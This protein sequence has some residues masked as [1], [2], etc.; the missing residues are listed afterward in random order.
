MGAIGF[1]DIKKSRLYA[2]DFNHKFRIKNKVPR[3]S[4]LTTKK[5]N[6]DNTTQKNKKAD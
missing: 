3:T 2:A 4:K 6:S 1:Y 5:T